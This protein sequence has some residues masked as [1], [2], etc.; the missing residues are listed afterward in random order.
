VKRNKVEFNTTL[1]CALLVMKQPILSSRL[2]L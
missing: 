2:K 1:F